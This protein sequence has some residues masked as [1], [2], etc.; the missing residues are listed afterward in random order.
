V[1][2]DF[3]TEPGF[4]QKLDF[5]L[6]AASTMLDR[7]AWVC[8][9]GRHEDQLT[10]AL[11]RLDA[12]DRAIAVTGHAADAG[13]RQATVD[14]VMSAFGSVDVLVNG[15]G[16]NPYYGSL[17]DLPE[18]TAVKMYKT[19]VLAALEWFKA[20]EKAWMGQHGGSVVNLASAA[21]YR[22]NVVHRWRVSA[23]DISRL[24]GLILGTIH[25]HPARATLRSRGGGHRAL[26][27]RPFETL[28]PASCHIVQCVPVR[29][30]RQEVGSE[31]SCFA[32][33]VRTPDPRFRIFEDCSLDGLVDHVQ[34][35]LFGGFGG[36]DPL[37][38]TGLHV[39]D[40]FGDPLVCPLR[41][42]REIA[43]HALRTYEEEIGKFV[44]CESQVGT[45]PISP[46]F[47]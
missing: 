24:A 9:T 23:D 21:A 39:P 31:G 26:L 28:V 7:G 41:T 25:T 45:R 8:L 18:D 38:S 37:E 35:L 30:H 16:I 34:P 19:N 44:S 36:F 17:S 14:T 13:H 11:S 27:A 10:D 22:S 40:A 2:W 47:G 20:V 12:G 42:P 33:N 29:V 43:C 6:A 15:V 46:M 3:E 1:A 5:G 4:Q 32:G